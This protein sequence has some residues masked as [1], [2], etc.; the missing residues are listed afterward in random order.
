MTITRSQEDIF[1]RFK[2]A[3]ASREDIFGFRLEVL[4]SAMT[5]D[6]LKKA[7]PDGEFTSEASEYPVFASENIDK[8]A[9]EYLVFAIGKAV[10]HR[11]ISASRSVDKLRE[12]AWLMGKDDVVEAMDEAGYTEYGV[13]KLKVF[14]DGMKYPFEFPE[15]EKGYYSADTLKNMAAGVPCEKG[16]TEGCG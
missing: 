2:E 14:A 15:S 7:M 4:A 12:M 8:E 9:R 10:N 1:T 11:G 5:L 13:P 16:C 3:Q 6:T